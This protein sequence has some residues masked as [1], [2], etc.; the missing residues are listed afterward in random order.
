MSRG[1]FP[2]GSSAWPQEAGQSGIDDG[3]EE[4]E[5]QLLQDILYGF[6]G[7]ESDRFRLDPSCSSFHF[8]RRGSLA[9]DSCL[10]CACDDMDDGSTEPAPSKRRISLTTLDNVVLERVLSTINS[11]WRVSRFCEAEL[12]ARS[13]VVMSFAS[14]TRTD[15]AEHVSLFAAK[16][17]SLLLKKQLSLSKL[18]LHADLHVSKLLTI[19]CMLLESFSEQRAKRAELVASSGESVVASVALLDMLYSK[20]VLNFVDAVHDEQAAAFFDH[21]RREVTST[22]IKSVLVPWM[23]RGTLANDVFQEFFVFRCPDED[24]IVE[25]DNTKSLADISAAEATLQQQSRTK[26]EKY[27]IR[28]E[29]LVPKFLRRQGLEAVA[30]ESGLYVNLANRGRP[31]SHFITADLTLPLP[32]MI[33]RCTASSNKLLLETICSG[34]ARNLVSTLRQLC[35]GHFFLGNQRDFLSKFL[36]HFEHELCRQSSEF[37]HIVEQEN[38]LF[39]EFLRPWVG[40]ESTIEC[41]LSATS[42]PSEGEFL[43]ETLH[44]SVRVPKAYQVVVTDES[45]HVYQT[46]SSSLLFLYYAKERFIDVTYR[47]FTLGTAR[48]MNSKYVKEFYLALF[49]MQSFVA[50]YAQFFYDEIVTPGFTTLVSKAN[51]MIAG[52]VIDIGALQEMHT[53][54]VQQCAGGSTLGDQKCR[55]IFA[56]VLRTVM[57]YCQLLQKALADYREDIMTDDGKKGATNE[58]ETHAFDDTLSRLVVE[59]DRLVEQFNDLLGLWLQ[60]AAI[61]TDDKDFRFVASFAGH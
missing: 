3:G 57:D 31:V 9:T 23:T 50:K 24:V 52:G 42:E 58:L 43:A 53:A 8:F 44:A 22:Y 45:I 55:E 5:Q 54:F 21:V 29:K 18:L 51:S 56:L 6:A 41:N 12:S 16:L 46:L 10:C 11:A 13:L 38:R 2:T 26:R 37:I 25:D 14:I 59:R 33:A 4:E 39:R 34:D 48:F 32:D 35:H 30:F 60:R 19:A 7:V 47:S 40:D 15:V 36:A 27:A 17:H 28:G 20:K 1:G 49:E 61:Q